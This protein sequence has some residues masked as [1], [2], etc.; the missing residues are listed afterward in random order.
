M[1]ATAAKIR[2]SSI[3]D[4]P[5]AFRNG[6]SGAAQ[7]YYFVG[8]WR[9]PTGSLVRAFLCSTQGTLHIARVA[10]DPKEL[11]AEELADCCSRVFPDLL[12]RLQRF[13]RDMPGVLKQPPMALAPE[14]SPA[15]RGRTSQMLDSI[16][17]ADLRPGSPPARRF[18]EL[19]VQ[20]MVITAAQLAIALQ[21][22]TASRTYVP[23]GQVL[24]AEKFITRKKLDAMLQRHGKRA[25]LGEIL[26]RAGRITAAQLAEAI[27][28]QRRISMPI[29]Q[30]LI[31]LGRLS[32]TAMRDALCTQLH[33]NFLDLDAIVIDK[34]L[35]RLVSERFARWHSL[36][37]L[38]QVDN[39]LVIAM[40]DP[41]QAAVIAR[42]ESTLGLQIET[43]TTTT[44]K[45][46]A[47]LH[48]LYGSPVPPDGPAVS[49][50]NILI[51]PIRDHV[52]AE[53]IVSGLRGV[54]GVV[55]SG[56]Q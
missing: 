24:L 17:T 38:F 40:D 14:F 20:E 48:R 39:V 50:C 4:G 49:G 28:Y 2:R 10:A 26:L 22:Q 15:D 25:R 21:L 1:L 19:L 56:S 18:G 47:A 16:Q 33:I 35:A 7:P 32:E 30:A 31:R 42:L 8:Q 51:G 34:D 41:S 52:V 9:L 45:F 55:R 29:G 46:G 6:E 13:S 3:Q 27:A 44:E 5:T 53:L 23:L 37:P 11:T 36:L 54:G 12:C 43:V